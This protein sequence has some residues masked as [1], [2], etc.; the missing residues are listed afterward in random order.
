M[1]FYI[2]SFFICY[3]ILFVVSEYDA[4]LVEWKK[5]YKF[6]LEGVDLLLEDECEF[7]EAPES[8]CECDDVSY[9]EIHNRKRPP[10]PWITFCEGNVKW[11]LG[12]TTKDNDDEVIGIKLSAKDKDVRADI[13]LTVT[14]QDPNTR[15]I[16]FE[17]KN[18]A[19]GVQFLTVFRNREKY[20]KD[21]AYIVNGG[22]SVELL[23]NV[24]SAKEKKKSFF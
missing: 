20:D 22:F 11:T 18:E 4:L 15:N 21:V 7:C 14:S 13:R 17:K 23:I 6:F 12:A 19:F 10:I 8:Q 2:Q 3:K 5:T 24:L 9:D 1:I 16:V